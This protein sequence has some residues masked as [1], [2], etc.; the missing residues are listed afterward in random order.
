MGDNKLQALL[1]KVAKLRALAA[2]AATQAEAE[3][4][5]AQAEAIIAKYQIDEASV[6]VTTEPEAIVH[7]DAAHTAKGQVWLG[8]LMHNI[9]RM[10]G[11]S[12]VSVRGA[13]G[14][15]YK[16]AGKR[17]DLAI[18]QYLVAW[19][20]VEIERLADCEHG[21]SAKNAF[22][23]GAVTGV[24]VAMQRQRVVENT[25]AG[26]AGASCAM[27]LVS[28]ADLAEARLKSAIG[29]KFRNGPGASIGDSGAYERGRRAGENLSAK[30]AM[31][32]GGGGS[33]H[34]MLT[35]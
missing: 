22:R 5:A 31:S 21:R 17:A 12:S 23:V 25:N 3:A 9:A 13:K 4:A 26:A 20:R 35:N 6:E 11:C 29:G 2:R 1:Q 14:T 19:L 34:R 32:G 10:H 33:A 7:E 8:M 18:V 30:P 27:V 16:L 15:T 24:I 28:R